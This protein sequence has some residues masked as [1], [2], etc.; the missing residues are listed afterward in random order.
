MNP[1]WSF[2]SMNSLRARKT[3]LFKVHPDS[4]QVGHLLQQSLSEM[5]Q[6]DTQME[7]YSTLQE[8]QEEWASL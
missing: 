4:I 7:G 1:F 6:V 8:F 5:T 2:F 3:E